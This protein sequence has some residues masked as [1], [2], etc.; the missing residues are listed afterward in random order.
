MSDA[1]AAA[2]YGRYAAIRRRILTEASQRIPLA[3]LAQQARALSLWDGKQVAPSDEM[4]LAVVFDL[5]VLDPLGGHGRGIDRQA[6]AEA[7]VPSSEEYRMLGAL[8]TA[9]FGLWRILGPHP[10]GGV[11]AESFPDGEPLVIW[12]RFLDRGR[13]PGAL[14]G[15]RIARPEEDLPMTCGAVVSLDSRAVERLLLGTPPG[16]GPV[17]PTQPLPD[18]G[19]ALERL[20]AEPAARLRLAALA[21]SPGFAAMVYR[22]AID[23]GLMGPV[24][25]RT[26][27]I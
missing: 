1:T 3:S 14:I 12:D 27:T 4:Q 25:G 8:A 15:A 13:A 20:V 16:R 9:P 23:L 17:I 22:V 7:P 10:E 6:K 19:P 26:P 21:R 2:R 18:E 24:A 5:G 11:R